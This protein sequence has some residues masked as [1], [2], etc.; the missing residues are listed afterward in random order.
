MLGVTV[1]VEG[2]KI[3]GTAGGGGSWA[4]SIV[5]ELELFVRLCLFA[6][7]ERY[8]AHATHEPALTLLPPPLLLLSLPFT[9]ATEV[10]RAGVRCIP[11]DRSCAI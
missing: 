9:F 4:S 5:V 1:K 8:A 10:F 3:C 7:Y 6:G 11:R 2:G